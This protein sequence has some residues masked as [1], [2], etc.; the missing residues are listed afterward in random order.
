MTLKRRDVFKFGLGF[1]P[2]F[3]TANMAG[4]KPQYN[5]SQALKLIAAARTQIGVTR[6]Y[7]GA[8][9]KITYPNGDIDRSIGVCTDVIIRAYRDAFNYDLQKRVHDDMVGNFS[10]YPKN[11]GL[12]T[13]D[14]NIDHRRVPNLQTFFT[15]KNA[16]IHAKLDLAGLKA[17]DLVT[18]MV[19]EKLPHIVI[20]S[21]RKNADGIPLVIHNIGRGTQE[22]DRLLEFPQ[23]GHYRLMV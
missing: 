13:T 4:A 9:Q 7:N 2:L 1:A 21:D 18:Q 8:Y 20:I 15:R 5:E 10:Q 19:N 17:G 3:L 12:K 16:R 6:F 22:E 11:W 23:T 14:R